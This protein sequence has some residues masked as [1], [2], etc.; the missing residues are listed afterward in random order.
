VPAALQASAVPPLPTSA[1]HLRVLGEQEHWFG[2]A[3]LPPQR[4]L[5]PQVE[6]HATTR[7]HDGLVTDALHVAP[8]VPEHIEASVSVQHVAVPPAGVPQPLLQPDAV[9]MKFGPQVS[10]IEPL[11]SLSP[12]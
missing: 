11:Q 6:P 12:G 10:S 3:A 5:F 2:V 4:R 8:L 1:T 7:P 9:Y